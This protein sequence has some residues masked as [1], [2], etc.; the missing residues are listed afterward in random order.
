MKVQIENNFYR[1]SDAMQFILKEY[2]GAITTDKDGKEREVSK[3]IGYYTNVQSALKKFLTMKI[4]DSTATTLRE[5]HDEIGS[6]RE[7]I[8]SKFEYKAPNVPKESNE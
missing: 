8:E 4:M 2:T 6:I 5:L 3:T 7:Y 1:E